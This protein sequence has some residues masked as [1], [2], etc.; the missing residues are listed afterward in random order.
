M[1]DH[2]DN[3]RWALRQLPTHPPRSGTWEAV[4]RSL[5]EE[6]IP[7][8]RALAQLPEHAPNAD[9]W[10]RVA[11]QLN[12]SG[13]LAITGWHR[14]AAAVGAFLLLSV[15]AFFLGRPTTDDDAVI[16]YH[17]ELAPL[18]DI[19]LADPLEQEAWDYLQQ[20]CQRAS[21]TTCEQPEF[22]ALRAHL[23][24]LTEEERALRAS[25]Q[26]LGYDPQLVKYQVRIE[27]MKAEAT[28]ELIQLVML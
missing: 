8:P 15:A 16:T 5:E 27:N 9:L 24:E 7:L 2:E 21:A 10:P 1:N 22:V 14:Y 18:P 3:L 28:R 17:E 20:L 13:R 11:D 25:M 12:A 4:E 23:R 19:D 26:E 6:E